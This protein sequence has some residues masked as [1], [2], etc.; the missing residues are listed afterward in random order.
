MSRLT[1]LLALFF[2]CLS[3]SP[4]SSQ[5]TTDTLTIGYTRAAPFILLEE[6]DQLKGLSVWL[7]EKIAED[8]QIPYE[9]KLMGFNDMLEALKDGSIDGSIN[10]LTITSDRSKYMDFTHSFFV[11]NSTV[12]IRKN[13]SFQKFINYARSILSL[14]FLSGLFILMIII[15]LFG[16]AAWW[17]ERKHNDTQFRKG[18]A[19][20]WDGLWW[21]AVTMTTVG[22]GDKSPKSTGGKV[23]ALIWMFTAL[24][25]ISGFTASIASTLTVNQLKWSPQGINDFKDQ[26]V[27][28]I[29]ASGTL[30]YLDTHFFSAVERY[31]G[32]AEGL[33]A[34][35]EQEIEAF[36]YDEPIMKYR[37]A[38]DPDYQAL[39]VLP[40]KFD[41]Q[42]YAFAFPKARYEVKE[43]VSQ[44]ILE[45]TENIEWRLILAEYDL[46]QL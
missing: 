40:V 8:L 5:I 6:E 24:L 21:S 1:A 11:S 43:R 12:A 2:L 29:N 32:L 36:L 45:Y 28:C 31:S 37:I 27:G 33:I 42:F 46:S 15:G 7:W 4:A 14:N 26:T 20:L 18:L 44:K 17:F 13:S 34:L 39:E 9:F 3:L 35:K 10:P 23:I 38:N 25:F 30:D 19:G 41:L 22:Y 16:L